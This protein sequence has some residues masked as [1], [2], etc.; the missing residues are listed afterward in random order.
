[1]NSPPRVGQTIG[2][3]DPNC[4]D[5]CILKRIEFRDKAARVRYDSK[6]EKIMVVRPSGEILYSEKMSKRATDQCYLSIRIALGKK[7]LGGQKGFFVMD[8]IFMA[9]DN[10]KLNNQ[11]KMLNKLS[12]DG[13]QIIYLT[14]KD[15]IKEALERISG[16]AAIELARLP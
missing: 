10:N 12:R 14:A 13:W 15:E 8:D 6:A 3:R 5:K 16:K 7:I 1:M 9:S 2:G 11:L 4:Q